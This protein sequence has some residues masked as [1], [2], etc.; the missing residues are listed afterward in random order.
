[1]RNFCDKSLFY[2]HVN[3]L[4]DLQE[5]L[6][7]LL[8]KIFNKSSRVFDIRLWRYQLNGVIA[9]LYQSRTCPA[10][11]SSSAKRIDCKGVHRLYECEECFLFYRDPREESDAMDD[12]YQ[13][14]YAEPGMT[15]DLP[16]DKEL[17]HLLATGFAGSAKNFSWHIEILKS[18]GMKPGMHMLEFGANWG[19]ATWQFEQAGFDVDAYELSRPRAAYGKKLGLNIETDVDM[20]KGPYDFI[21]SCHVLEHV[22]NPK[23]TLLQ[24]MDWL[25]PG[26][27][28]VA[29]TPN[30][31]LRYRNSSKSGFHKSWGLVHP[32]LLTDQFI[33]NLF[34][35]EN[36]LVTSDDQPVRVAEWDSKSRYIDPCGGAGLFFAIK[37][38]E[39]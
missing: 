20:I 1:M 18:L 13:D 26:G 29:H 34:A 12:F 19:Y 22:P 24:Q 11:D 4:C 9:Y 5:S 3:C 39:Y 33:Q 36:L 35:S 6:P 37:R 17:E 23:E 15:T 25:Q 2:P 32:V 38:D 7:L 10:C 31:S 21:Y 27:M 28:L 16:T 8:M 14:G 30:G